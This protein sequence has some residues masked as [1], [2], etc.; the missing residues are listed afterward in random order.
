[1]VTQSDTQNQ[2]RNSAR[3]AAITIREGVD[4]VQAP[5]GVRSKVNCGFVPVF[6]NVVTET[7]NFF[8][9]KVGSDRIVLAAADL[10]ARGT[11]ISRIRTN[12]IEGDTLQMKNCRQAQLEG[13]FRL[14]PVVDHLDYGIELP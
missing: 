13:A 2:V 7:L 1:M 14:E 11:K 3:S 9:D 12:A 10:D 6:I 8:S 5:K 4:P